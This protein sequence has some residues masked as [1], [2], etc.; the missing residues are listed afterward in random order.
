MS[1]AAFVTDFTPGTRES[2]YA[3]RQVSKRK[4]ECEKKV[5]G[6]MSTIN[7]WYLREVSDQL[8]EIL[9]PQ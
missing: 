7:L 9:L 8:R 5:T 4:I 3:D 1:Y 2:G 6:K